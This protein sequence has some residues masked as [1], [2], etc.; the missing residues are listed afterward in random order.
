MV[1][2]SGRPTVPPAGP[3]SYC[4]SQH[5]HSSQPLFQTFS[6]FN[7]NSYLYSASFLACYSVLD[8]LNILILV[9]FPITPPSWCY[10]YLHPTLPSFLQSRK[11][12]FLFKANSSFWCLILSSSLAFLESYSSLC[13]SNS[14]SLLVLFFSPWTCSSTSSYPIL[15]PSSKLPLLYIP[16]ILQSFIVQ[17][18]TLLKMFCLSYYQTQ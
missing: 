10:L 14:F 18:I 6:I 7:P 13:S 5:Y 9:S 15:P 11:R 2:N 1:S 17:F 12:Y 8:N 16:F 3:C 4:L